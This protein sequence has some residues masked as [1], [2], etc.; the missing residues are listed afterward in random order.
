[1]DRR[2]V[3]MGGLAEP[4]G[5]LKAPW[6]GEPLAVKGAFVR[7]SGFA[8]RPRP[9]QRPHPPIFIGGGAPRVLRLAGRLGDIVGINFNKAAGELGAG[10]G[11]RL[12]PGATPGEVGRGPGW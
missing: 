11:A 12:A 2:G 5:L 6:A 7:A 4:V 8:G 1:M 9:V 10:R 3:G